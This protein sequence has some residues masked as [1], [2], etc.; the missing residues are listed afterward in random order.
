MPNV[1]IT[2]T[3]KTDLLIVGSGIGGLSCSVEAHKKGINHILITKP[4]LVLGQVFF[5]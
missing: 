4:N 5:H 3:L 2:Q 1:Q